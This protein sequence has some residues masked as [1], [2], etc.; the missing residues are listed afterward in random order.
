MELW[1]FHKCRAERNKNLREENS[2]KERKEDGKEKYKH[3]H[4]MQTHSITGQAGNM[5]A[6]NAFTRHKY[7]DETLTHLTYSQWTSFVQSSYSILFTYLF[8]YLYFFSCSDCVVSPVVVLRYIIC[9]GY[10]VFRVLLLISVHALILAP[11]QCVVLN[12]PKLTT[13]TY[14]HRRNRL[15]SNTQLNKT[16]STRKAAN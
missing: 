14:S 15:E 7:P 9:L 2:E 10:T 3:T 13:T 5:N 8:F 4:T 11:I 6:L 16:T 12:S 1:L